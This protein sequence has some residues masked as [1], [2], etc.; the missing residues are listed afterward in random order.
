MGVQGMRTATHS[1]LEPCGV[2]EPLQSAD[3]CSEVLLSISC[4]TFFVEFL[5]GD[6]WSKTFRGQVSVDTSSDDK[7]FLKVIHFTK[8]SFS[9]RESVF[10]K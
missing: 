2:R 6:S 1:G 4:E 10:V 3:S 7:L 9:A 8:P 5:H